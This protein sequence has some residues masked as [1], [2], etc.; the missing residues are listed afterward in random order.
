MNHVGDP[1]E[2]IPT[3][4]LLP[5]YIPSANVSHKEESVQL[6]YGFVE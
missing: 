5:F 3:L 6:T 2:V 1:Q 4:D